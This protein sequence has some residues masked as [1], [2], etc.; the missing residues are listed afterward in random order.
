MLTPATTIQKITLRCSLIIEEE[1]ALPALFEPSSF[2]GFSVRQSPGL[3][4]YL[5][6][7]TSRSRASHRL[8]IKWKTSV[9]TRRAVGMTDAK[10]SGFPPPCQA[11]AC[12]KTYQ[13]PQKCHR[14]SPQHAKLVPQGNPAR[15]RAFASL[16]SLRHRP[17]ISLYAVSSFVIRIESRLPA[18]KCKRAKMKGDGA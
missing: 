9:N 13:L 18:N 8:M 7:L 17:D 14:P 5:W 16:C 4:S 11:A 3:E 6:G 2:G 15:L 12:A 1:Y 10:N